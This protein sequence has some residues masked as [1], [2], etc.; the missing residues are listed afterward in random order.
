MG[1]EKPP[2][3][4]KRGMKRDEREERKA[5]EQSKKPRMEAKEGGKAVAAAEP[6]PPR[7]QP[8]A[9]A[10]PPF[11]AEAPKTA[12]EAELADMF[13]ECGEILGD[14]RL[15]KN[16]ATGQC[17]GIGWITFATLSGIEGRLLS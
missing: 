15:M 11:K 13:K 16:P 12:T 1:D 5:L 14:V 10:S 2:R 8:V 4:S 6:L 17:K 3:K 9:V 7:V